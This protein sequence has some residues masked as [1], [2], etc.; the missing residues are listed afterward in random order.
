MWAEQK[1]APEPVAKPS[2]GPETKGGTAPMARTPTI[3]P[4]REKVA[5]ELRVLEDQLRHELMDDEERLELRERII[6]IRRRLNF[7]LSR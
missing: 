2:P 7:G 1:T 5:E 4:E 3:R 6:R